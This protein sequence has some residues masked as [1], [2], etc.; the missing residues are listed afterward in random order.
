MI[1]ADFFLRTKRTEGMASLYTRVKKRNPEIKWE[2]VNTG[3]NVDIEAWIKAKKSIPAWSKYIREEGKE[4]NEKLDKV[5]QTIDLLF[6]EGKIKSNDDKP[7]LENALS[8]IANNDALKVRE[9]VAARQKRQRELDKKEQ[10]RKRKLILNFYQYFLDGIT[11]KSIRHGNN[12]IYSQ[13]SVRIWRDFGKHLRAFCP[14]DM[15]F[16]DISK[17]FADKFSLYLEKQGYMAN[18][19]NKYVVCF[20]KL[21]NIAAEEG[22]NNNAVSLRVWKERTVHDDDKRAEIYLTNEELDAL[23]DMELDGKEEQIRDLFLIGVFCAQRISDFSRLTKKNFKVTSNGTPVISI[24]QKKTGTYVEVPYMDERVDEIGEKYNYMFPSI[25]KRDMNRYLKDILKK[26]GQTKPSLMELYPTALSCA[27]LR[28]EKLYQEMSRKVAK[29]EKLG[30]EKNKYYKKMKA[31]AE[32]HNGSPLY[33][34][35]EEGNVLMFKYELI[36]SH[37]ARRSALT[38]L[39]KTGVFDNREMMAISGHKSERVFEKYIKVG[40]SEQADRIYKKMKV[41]NGGK[42]K[43]VG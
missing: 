1:M 5:A 36:V 13:D 26:L 29:G 12:A 14:K 39:Y 28:K 41:L 40:V 4:V 11:D 43:K 16:D 25:P 10:I 34:R 22:I 23:Y 32:E 7:I 20:R 37:T 35:D 6:K 42:E 24:S 38:N 33:M 30:A 9:E 21:C 3:I 19:V 8:L 31:Y 2:Y 15:S 17:P 27:E 18:T